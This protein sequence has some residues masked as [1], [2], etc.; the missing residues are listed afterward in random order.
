MKKISLLIVIHFFTLFLS[1]QKGNIQ[2]A[3]IDRDGIAIPGATVSIAEL[4]LTAVTD[5]NGRFTLVNIPGGSYSLLITYLGFADLQQRITVLPKETTLITLIL[6]PI[7]IRLEGVEVASQEKT[8][9]SKALNIQKSNLNVTNV[10]STDQIGKFPDANIGDAVKRISGITIQVNQGEARD[11]IIRG[12]SPEL[13]SVMLNGSRIPS[14]EGD[15]R[16]IQLDLIPS[17]MIQSIEINKTLTPDMD[18]DALGGA[19][20]LVTRT[21]PQGF[22]LS[23]TLG[24][25]LNF[26]RNK[27]IWNGAFLVGNRSANDKFGWMLSASINDNDFGSD[28][29]EA[30]WGDTFEYNSGATDE[31]GEPV[32]EEVDVSAYPTILE[33]QPR[34]IQRVR[35]SFAA[36]FDYQINSS[37]SLFLKSIYNWRDD[38]ENG[39]V[40]EQEILE[41]AEI[42]TAAFSIDN[43]NLT[44]FPVLASR[45]TRGG[46]DTNRNK[47]ARLEDQRMQNYSLGGNHLLG[48]VKID[49]LT[50]FSRASEEKT[51]ERTA[52]FKSEYTVFPNIS[53]PEFPFFVP[54]NA[55]DPDD[56][57]NFEYDELIEENKFTKEE[58]INFFANVAFPFDM[59][60]EGNGQFKF[61]VRG[62][63]K[64]K[65]RENN[66][67]VFDQEA[68][69]PTLADVPV[70]NYSDPDYLAGSQYQA[71][72]FANE[73]WL[74]GLN[75]QNGDEVADEFLRQNF[76]ADE[77]V[78][79]AY[80]M[81]S[82]KLSDQI[83]LIAGVRLEHTR[84]KADANIIE[85]GIGA[86]GR[87]NA[88]ESYNNFLPGIH[89][90]YALTPQAI[91][92]MAW[93]N[94]LARPNYVDLVPTQDVVFSDREILLGN[95]G[96]NPATSSNFDLTGEYYFESVGIFS[97]GF[98]YKNIKNF[99]YTFKSETTDE[100]FGQG[101]AGFDLFQPLNGEEASLLGIEIT[102][103]RRLDFLPG[104]AKNFTLDMNYTYLNAK[105]EGI[106]DVNGIERD[107]LDL[108]DTPPNL[109]NASLA[110]EGKGYHARIS[111]NFSDAYITN[112][113]GRSFE[114]IFYDRQFF[115]DFNADVSLNRHLSIYVGLNNITNQPLRMYQGRHARTAKAEYYNRR[116]TF[117]LKYDIFKKQ[118]TKEN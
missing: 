65:I 82:Q 93:T 13:N 109:F 114:D 29:I 52:E 97:T 20:N 67:L 108:S 43:D 31:H 94:T 101:T 45:Q 9:H 89:I 57:S 60:N 107:D 17:D 103:Q 21:S 50:S 36:N 112:V 70:T 38:R 63:L 59:F 80:L 39:F 79:A 62:R 32:L 47:N 115:L 35:R 16:N 106:R 102:F 111:A 34:W 117:G 51:H 26:I 5:L 18:A 54:E 6:N 61:G 28:N 49:W 75:L 95:S 86:V 12:L 105:T 68:N 87:T 99:I 27:R 71:G 14:A 7:G 58:D 40:F 72:Q 83:S 118:N 66:F 96:L 10:V 88:K 90:K 4:D 33:V 56:L 15:N 11:I 1:A 85:E 77:N 64:S 37:H 55:L 24:S 25:G 19:V 91:I 81:T 48:G 110:Y 44:R 30:A 3:I 2:G 116:L 42:D 98:F 78:F 113:G 76:S 22:R 46:V 8:A 41:A 23:A 53:D 84:F 104:F 100:S 92:R 74:G 73:I 69:Y